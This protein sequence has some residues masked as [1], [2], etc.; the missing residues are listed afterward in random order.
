MNHIPGILKWTCVDMCGDIMA[1]NSGEIDKVVIFFI[2]LV[3]EFN[4]Y[5]Y[6][7]W[8]ILIQE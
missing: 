8:S 5:I 7:E 1:L 6:I 3:T 2:I 4:I